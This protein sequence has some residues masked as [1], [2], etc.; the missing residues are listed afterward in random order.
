MVITPNNN[1][2]VLTNFIWKNADDLRGDFPHTQFGRIILPF[3]ILRRLECVLEAN[4]SKVLATYEQFKDQG[5]AL[6]TILKNASQ[7]PFYN[8]SNYNLATL[9]GNKT[10][11]NIKDYISKFS[12]NVRKIFEG[13]KFAQIIEELDAANLLLLISSNFAKIDLH[14]DV[15]PDRTMSNVY[16]LI[17][18]ELAG[19]FHLGYA[20]QLTDKSS[21]LFDLA[22]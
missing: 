6:D 2:T 15:V 14:P 12:E 16:E 10:K 8:I 5:F 19:D 4:K 13:F 1:D 20:R 22:F 21:L 17:C 7:R 18:A 11:A 9:G 3:T